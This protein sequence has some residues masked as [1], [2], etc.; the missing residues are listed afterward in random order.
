MR[1][2]KATRLAHTGAIMAWHATR[3][4]HRTGVRGG[5]T[6]EWERAVRN[7]TT[8]LVMLPP[9]HGP[10]ETRADHTDRDLA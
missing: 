7:T 2:L 6:F 10:L 4:A 5:S 9:R 8:L 3:W 1:N